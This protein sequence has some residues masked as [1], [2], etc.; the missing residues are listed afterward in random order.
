MSSEYYRRQVEQHQEKIA[1]LQKEKGRMAGKASDAI[2]KASAAK[3]AASRSSQASTVQSKL[4][5]AQRYEE[6]YARHQK[7]IARLEAK[8]TDELKRKGDAE[9]NQQREEKRETDA[10]RQKEIREARE[11]E[12][13][14]QRMEHTT[15]RHESHISR[16]SGALQDHSRLHRT[17]FDAIE[18]LS[19]LPKKIAVLFVASNPLDQKQL[20]LDEEARAIEEMIRKAKHRDSVEFRT[21]WAARPMDILQA[22]NEHNPRIVHFSGHG[23]LESDLVMQ[24]SHGESRLVSKEAIAASLAACSEDIQIVFFNTCYSRE[25]AEAVVKHVPTAIG[26]N[27]SIG[28]EAARIFS[29]QFY[30][31]LGFGLS[32]KKAFDQA[33][34]ALMLE[35]IPEEL[36]P[37]LFHGSDIDPSRLII[38][39]P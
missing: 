28:D 35:G 3:Q 10:R 39:Q 22:V 27:T 5:E 14:A 37:E 20:R 1:Q 26:M 29:S 2:S 31:A 13:R 38:V 9:R 19:R 4:K 11:R 36:T 8:T 33:Q 24:G 6:E 21:Q 34:A 18:R 17:A 32:V 15:L 7:E 23:S 12:A 16:M 30:S 25:Q